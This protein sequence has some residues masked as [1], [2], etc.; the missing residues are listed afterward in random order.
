[1]T[2]RKAVR[3]MP[4]R[5][6]DAGLDAARGALMVLGVL[7][8]AAN[9]YIPGGNWIVRDPEVHP[10]FGWLAATIH[11]FRMPAFFWLSG[12][13]FARSALRQDTGRLLRHR[14]RRLLLPLAATWMTFNVAQVWV[15]ACASGTSVVT[16]LRDGVPLFHLWFLFDLAVF[17]AATALL[18]PWLQRQP[19]HHPRG[20]T[21]SAWLV[22]LGI[23]GGAWALDVAV[24]LTGFAYVDPWGLTSLYRLAS[25]APFFAAGLVMHSRRD[26]LIGVL[27]APSWLLAPVFVAAL[28]LDHWITARSGWQAEIAHFLRIVLVAASSTIVVGLFPRLFRRDSVLTRLF[29]DAAYSIYL[30]QHLFI[31]ALATALIGASWGPWPKFVL[32]TIAA[33]GLA[34]ALHLL[35][36]RRVSVL[37]FIF[38]GASSSLPLRPAAHLTPDAGAETFPAL[39]EPSPALGRVKP[40]AARRATDYP[41]TAKQPPTP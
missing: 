32:N 10:F 41:S 3:P 1:M 34:L 6:R 30:F 11:L 16:A 8:H 29:A 12:Y 19:W 13:L 26:W 24:R 18:W 14:L 23:A 20:G 17:T 31:V 39:L 37:R 33:T 7:L 40:L 4:E 35:L 5:P 27:H 15:A 21:A 22:I 25:Y 28:V 38:N 2:G 9:P 36:I